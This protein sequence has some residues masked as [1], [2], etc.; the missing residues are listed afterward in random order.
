[1]QGKDPLSALDFRVEVEMENDFN[2]AQF[3]GRF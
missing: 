3:G 1:M 2:L